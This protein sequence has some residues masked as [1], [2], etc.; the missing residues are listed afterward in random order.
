[1]GSESGILVRGV[2]SISCCKVE[3]LPLS[4]FCA[5][6]CFLPQ[7]SFLA[8]FLQSS[9]CAQS[10]GASPPQVLVLMSGALSSSLCPR[11]VMWV[12]SSSITAHGPCPAHPR[13][14]CPTPLCPKYQHIQPPWPVL[15]ATCHHFV[16][17]TGHLGREAAAVLLPGVSGICSLHTHTD[18]QRLPLP[19]KQLFNKVC[20]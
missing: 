4:S 17:Q 18:T 8:M 1:M 3:S 9:I 15:W 13:A 14:S 2:F 20:K 10:F 5:F 12:L 7:L 19:N 11:R 16:K 6:S